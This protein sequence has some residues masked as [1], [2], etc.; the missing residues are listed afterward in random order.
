MKITVWSESLVSHR[1]QA[2][3]AHTLIPALGRQMQMDL[4]EFKAA[5]G[6]TR[7]IESQRETEPDSGGS[8]L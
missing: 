2:V 6:Y 8:H 1:S 5:L 7:L 4:C 3:M